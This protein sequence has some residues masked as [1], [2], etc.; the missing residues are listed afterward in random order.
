[1]GPDAIGASAQRNGPRSGGYD[2]E[3]DG[4]FLPFVS[5]WARTDAARDFASSSVGFLAP[6]KTFAAKDEALSDDCFLVISTSV[7]RCCAGV[8]WP[9]GLKV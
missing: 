2:F 8:R 6:L 1:M 7:N 9:D 3:G 4:F 5:S